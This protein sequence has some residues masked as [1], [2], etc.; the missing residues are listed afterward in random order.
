MVRGI[1]KA[2][3]IK[4][5]VRAVHGCGVDIEVAE[6]SNLREAIRAARNVEAHTKIPVTA[7]GPGGVCST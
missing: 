4:A 7:F 1:L 2:L 3:N 5:S 6:M